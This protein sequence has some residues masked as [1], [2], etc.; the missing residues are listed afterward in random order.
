MTRRMTPD[1]VDR[2]SGSCPEP[3]TDSSYSPAMRARPRRLLAAST[4]LCATL[5]ASVPVVAAPS[6]G[7]LPPQLTLVLQV[8]GVGEVPADAV[9]VALNVTVTNPSADGFLTVYPCG[10]RPLASNLNYVADQTVP[11]FV[12]SGLSDRGEICIDTMVVVDVI[13]DLAGYVPAASP[14]V[15]LAAPR[16]FL[17]TRAGLGAPLARVV[18]GTVLEVP[19]AGTFEVPSDA[20]TVVFNA[21][22]VHPVGSGFLTVFP[23]GQSIPETSSL[24]YSPGGIVPN[25]VVSAVG[26]GGRV[27]FYSNVTTD[28]V[29]D[30]AAFVPG[31]AD[32]GVTTLERPHRLVD[33]RIGLG[34]PA[35]PIG[36]SHRPVAVAGLHGVP[37]DVVTAIVN[38]TATNAEGSG[39]AAALP[40]GGGAPLVSNLNFTPGTNVANLALVKLGAAGS[41]CLTA[42]RPV[43]MVVDVLGYTR[44]GDAFVP[45]SPRRIYD[46]REGVDPACALGIRQGGTTF[47]LVDLHTGEVGPTLVDVPAYEVPAQAFV[48]GACHVQIIG[49]ASGTGMSMTEVDRAGS[50]VVQQPFVAGVHLPNVASTDVGLVGLRHNSLDPPQILDPVTGEVW[51]D[52]PPT[53]THGADGTLD[54]WSFVGASRDGSILATARVS[55]DRFATEVYFWTAEG[56]FISSLREPKFT[57]FRR[58]STDGSY[59][60]TGF[61][62]GAT[63][64]IE[65]LVMTLGGA[66]VTT[67]AAGGLAHSVPQ[68]SF[69]TDGSVLACEPI[70]PLGPVGGPGRAVRWDLFNTPKPLVAGSD[71]PCLIAAG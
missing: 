29:A 23:C 30:V 47:Q 9:G 27:C 63:P 41:L 48:D 36:A 46:S 53:T 22:A 16:R 4:M 66:P 33:T 20:S 56:D 7:A 51:F 49:T 65:L 3:A 21:T 25:L 43:D 64:H 15:P 54:L 69:I 44:G 40:C 13:V 59:L 67:L 17:D 45:L 31:G 60:M 58:L 39:Y 61:V 24:N 32:A 5:A 52:L 38:L 55:D 57:V 42:N 1:T 10:D 50:V 12:L 14:L 37:P 35:T 2:G 71:V 70:D 26:A 8:A 62:T 68:P 19:L 11:N 28:V 34:G 6:G 18:G